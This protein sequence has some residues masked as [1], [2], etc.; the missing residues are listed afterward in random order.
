MMNIF[1]LSCLVVSIVLGALGQIFFKF[2]VTKEAAQGIAFLFALLKNV[3]IYLG[4][5]SYGIS[6]ILWM[7]VLKYYDV[8]F[9]R[10]LTSI[11]YILTYVFAI[12]FLSE[13]FTPW[14][15]AGILLITG[16]VVL[17]SFK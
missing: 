17:L 5:V 10:P 13:D 2:G 14:R 6:F 9:A 8:S 3:W 12:V 16:G 15:L 7:F 11:G 4:A 1:Y